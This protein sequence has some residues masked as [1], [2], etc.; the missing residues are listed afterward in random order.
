MEILW[1]YRNYLH[2]YKN[3]LPRILM[4]AKSW[5]WGCL[6]EIYKLL[7]DWPQLDPMVA[8]ELL[9]PQFPD[10]KIREFAINIISKINTDDLVDFLPQLIQA[11][12]FESYHNSSL[13]QMLLEQSCK[14][15]RFA[16]QFFCCRSVDEFCLESRGILRRELQVLYERFEEK[17]RLLM[18]YNPSIEVCGVDIK[19][20]SYFTSNAFPLKLVFK[21][22]NQKA[23]PVYAM[24][25]VGDDLRQDMLTLQMV[26]IMDQLW[27]KQSLDLK[28]IT[29]SCLATGPKKGIIELV[30]ESDTLRKIQ[31]SSG[32]TGSFKDRPIKEWLQRHNPTE[33]EYRK[34]V[35][36]F[37]YSCAGYCV[38][39]YVLGVGDR[40]NDN[41]MLKQSGHLF[42][43]DFSK[44]LGDTQMFGSFKRDRVPFV[45]TSDMVYVINDGEKQTG[46][47]QHFIDLCSQ[48]FNILRK[49]HDLFY[50]L[51]M[52]MS[53]SGIPGVTEN[54]A[55]Y[56]KRALLPGQTDAQASSMFTRMIE[57]S[58]KSVF[59]QFNFFIHNLAQLK[60]S[61]HQEGA[62]LSFV[63]KTYSQ[64]TDG[65]IIGVKLFSIQ[66][67]YTPD[68][69]Y[70]S[71]TTPYCFIYYRMVLGRSNIRSVAETRKVEIEQFL[72]SLLIKAP[73]ISQCDLVYTFFHPLLRDEQEEASKMNYSKLREPV[74]TPTNSITS[75]IQGEIKLSLHY[76][77]DKF[78][79]MIIHVRNLVSDCRGTDLPSPYVKTYLLPDPDKQTKRK[80]KIARSSAN[81]TYNELLEYKMSLEQIRFRML[82]VTVWDHDRLGENNFLGAVYLKLHDLDLSQEDTR[83]HPLQRLQLTN[84]NFFS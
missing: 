83:W 57:E 53:R 37:T 14:S 55:Q 24:Y 49:H 48:A 17:G 66:K 33:L 59:T 15:I 58:V 16:H 63:P 6:S 23:D 25:K 46:K 42:H 80:T 68:K 76:K 72:E 41:I 45:L 65:K 74:V 30:T 5:D 47:F 11:L 35:E 52:L 1:Q 26:N 64:Q 2:E 28:M 44:F 71:K 38:A 4:A 27:L 21:N 3:L 36:N 7:A 73:E 19:S 31:I 51:F 62:L 13:A 78:H 54:A 34:A 56:V 29:F 81:P 70:K 18:P 67:R 77:K 8:F 12:K 22:S 82:Q 69:H 20:C 60:F 32:V 61:S 39:T 75:G 10:L 43:I 9:L 40:H 50:S 79:V 84:N